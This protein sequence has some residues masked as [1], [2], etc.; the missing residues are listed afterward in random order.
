MSPEAFEALNCLCRS[1]FLYM[2][3]DAAERHCQLRRGRFQLGALHLRYDMKERSTPQVR[4]RNLT[5]TSVHQD[6]DKH[7]VR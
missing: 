4:G 6:A 5:M 7:G 1:L 2:K 3:H